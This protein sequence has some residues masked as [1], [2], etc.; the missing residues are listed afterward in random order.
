MFKLAAKREVDWPVEIPVP[1]DGGGVRKCKQNVRFALLTS[2]EQDAVYEA[3]GSDLDLL[4]RV[5][6][7]WAENDFRD[8]AD[9]PLPFTT[10]NLDRVLAESF[11]RVA[12]VTAYLQACNGREAARKN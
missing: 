10:E 11:A 6:R 7:G 12:F 4:H 8:E 3:G 2:K 1:V 9:Q 5:V